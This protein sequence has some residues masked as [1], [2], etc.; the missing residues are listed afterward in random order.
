M[1]WKAS[2][3]PF[4]L[5]GNLPNTARSNCSKRLVQ[6]HIKRSELIRSGEWSSPQGWLTSL[7]GCEEQRLFAVSFCAALRRLGA[8]PRILLELITRLQFYTS[9][10]HWSARD[11]FS[12]AFDGPIEVSMIC[13]K[14]GQPFQSGPKPTA[15]LLSSVISLF[16]NYSMTMT[17]LFSSDNAQE[18][19]L[20]RI[21]FANLV[22]SYIQGEALHL[23]PVRSLTKPRRLF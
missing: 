10:L 22:S 16:R 2:S 1:C 14:A 13:R 8:R 6:W 5:R 18:E 19:L 4:S 12:A 23:D 9:A 20:P 17:Q 11:D 15:P 3:N 7:C 21:Y